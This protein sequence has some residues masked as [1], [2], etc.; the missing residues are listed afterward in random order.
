MRRSLY[1][2]AAVLAL[3]TASAFADETEF[4]A[5]L[6]GHAIL[7]ANTIISA[8]E[9]APEH[10]RTSGKFTTADRKRTEAL[11]TV[12]GKDGVRE[13]GLSLPFDGQPMQGFSGIKAMEDGSFWTLSDNGFGN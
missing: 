13:T 12:M 2:A 9:N 10:L 7:P 6:A 4:K 3:S 11:D 1:L 8:P 5:T